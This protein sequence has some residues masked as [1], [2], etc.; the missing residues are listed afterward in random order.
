MLTYPRLVLEQSVESQISISCC[1]T[2][3]LVNS[4]IKSI[5][6]TSVASGRQGS[7]GIIFLSLLSSLE[8]N[9]R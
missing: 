9:S 8:L 5:K 4:C 6:L 7:S 3:P 1:H 2:R